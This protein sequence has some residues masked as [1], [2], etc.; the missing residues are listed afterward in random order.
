MSV[1][2]I[3]ETCPSC[4][5]P[6]LV[7]TDTRPDGHAKHFSCGHTHY[8]IHLEDTLTLHAMLGFKARSQGKGRPYMEGKVGED[9]HRNSGRWMH[10]ERI[11]DRAKDWYAE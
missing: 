11:I 5:N 4:K 3:P 2:A 8:D 9:L 7:T 1:E 6:T 10:L